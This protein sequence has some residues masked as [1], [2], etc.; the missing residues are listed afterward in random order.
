[1]KKQID[2]YVGK[3]GEIKLGKLIVE[4]NIINVKN[5]YGRDRF[6]ISPVAGKGEIWVEKVSLKK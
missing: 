4:V 6:L 1:M 5:S 3:K 2:E